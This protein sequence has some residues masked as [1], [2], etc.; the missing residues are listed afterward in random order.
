MK[1]SLYRTED[2]KALNRFTVLVTQRNEFVVQVYAGNE[3][4]A[5]DLVRDLDSDQ[6]EE[7]ETDAR[8]DYEVV[9]EYNG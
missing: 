8:W 4:E 7:Y 9:G 5:I 6:I 2:T 1:S 3:S